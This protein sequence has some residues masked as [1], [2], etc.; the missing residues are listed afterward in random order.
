MVAELHQVKAF[1]SGSGFRATETSEQAAEGLRALLP[2][3]LP[4]GRGQTEMR[5]SLTYHLWW[6]GDGGVN[7]APVQKALGEVCAADGRVSLQPLVV[8]LPGDV[9]DVMGSDFAR[10][11]RSVCPFLSKV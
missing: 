8:H 4:S 10:Y 6:Y 9:L 7:A 11:A 2:H 1:P 3:V 5:M